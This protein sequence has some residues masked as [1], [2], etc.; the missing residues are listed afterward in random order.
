MRRGTTIKRYVDRLDALTVP[1]KDRDR[2]KAWIADQRRVQLLTGGLASAFAAR[3]DARIATLSQ[4]IAALDGANAA[5]A[6]KYGLAAC[7]TPSG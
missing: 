4:Q 3:D 1:D 2:L 6:A 5:F 7:A